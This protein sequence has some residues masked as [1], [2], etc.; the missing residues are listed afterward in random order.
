[1]EQPYQTIQAPASAQLV[2]ERSRFIGHCLE[3]AD[4]AAAKD[5]VLQIRAEHAQANHNCY[6]YRIGNGAHP[7]EYFNDHGEPSGTAGKPILGA[8]QR[9][10]LTHVVVVVTRYFGGKKLG[11]RG[12]IEAYGQAATEVLNA[13]GTVTRIPCFDVCLTYGY[14]DHSLILHRL[15]Q[16]EAQVIESL[17]GEWVT[18][19]LRIP[20]AQRERFQKLL[21]ELPVTGVRE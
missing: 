1:M 10:N 3:V 19:R 2:V 11:V 18:T 16:V 17:F 21:A 13:A 7:L 12:L 5:F 14:A 20:A 15:G 4:E 9:R 8:I 6:A